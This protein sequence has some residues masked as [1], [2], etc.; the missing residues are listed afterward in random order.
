MRHALVI[1]TV[2]IVYL[3]RLTLSDLSIFS[4]QIPVDLT[5]KYLRSQDIPHEV[6]GRIFL[7]DSDIHI[8]AAKQ[9]ALGADPTKY[10][11]QHPPFIKYLYG[12]AYLLWGNPLLAQVVLG[13]I[14]LIGTYGFGVRYGFR[15]KGRTSRMSLVGARPFDHRPFP[16]CYA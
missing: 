15:K 2:L 11:F 12:F 6:H 3:V 7:S 16:I 10:N 8:A 13:M 9:Y 14:L 4:Y 1:M 5:E